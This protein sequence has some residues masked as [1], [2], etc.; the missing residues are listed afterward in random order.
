MRKL[1]VLLTIL[2]LIGPGLGLVCHCCPL[3]K[4]DQAASLPVLTGEN[5]GC[6]PETISGVER[7]AR[8]SQEVKSEGLFSRSLFDLLAVA[9]T[10]FHG[11][12]AKDVSFSRAVSGPPGSSPEKPLYLSLQILRL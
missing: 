11:F 6:C 1:A 12:K 4:A 3:N 8:I 5:C 2:A 10:S 7:E 9:L